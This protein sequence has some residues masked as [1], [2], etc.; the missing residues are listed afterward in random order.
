MERKKKLII[1]EGARDR[2]L[3]RFMP[4]FAKRGINVSISQLKQA[5]LAKFVNE[6]G[7]HNLSLDSNFYLLGVAKYYFNGDLTENRQLNLL[8]P[9][10][11][12]RFNQE[13]CQRLDA[14]IEILRNAYIDS[15]GTKW[16]QPED[17]GELTINKLLR[18]YG[19][20][21]NKALGIATNN[22]ED[23]GP[24]VSEDYS[25]GKDYTYEILYNFE[26]ARKYNAATE[27]GAWCITYGKA[28]F[29]GYV[30]RLGIHYVVF[31]RK[32]Y[33]NIPRK[34]GKGYTKSKPQDEYGNSLI[35]VLQSNS[36]PQ[37]I[38]ITSRWNHGAYNDNTQ[39]TEADHAYTTE[40]FL[41]VIGCDYS[42]LERAY[43]QW[44]E[45]SKTKK[46]KSG[47]SAAETRA[48][49]LDALRKLKYAQMLINGGANPFSIDFIQISLM[50]SNATFYNNRYR[51]NIEK[52]KPNIN[53]MFWVSV[54]GNGKTYITFID[55]RQIKYDFLVPDDGYYGSRAYSDK[56]V[57]LIKPNGY[58]MVY[59]K[60]RRKFLD[61][62]GTISFK[63]ASEAFSSYS[64][65]KSNIEYGILALSN[66]QLAL[67]DTTTLKPVKARNGSPWFET[68]IQTN[69]WRSSN[70]DNRGRIRMPVFN[71][72]SKTLKMVYDS[73]AGEV[74]YFNTG[75]GSFVDI[76]KDIPS[77]F[78]ITTHNDL[79]RELENYGDYVFFTEGGEHVNT[80][81]TPRTPIIIKNA[82]V[83]DVVEVNGKS[84]FLDFRAAHNVISFR[85]VDEVYS[86]YAVCGSDPC[87]RDAKLITLPNGEPVRTLYRCSVHFD[88][89]S[90]WYLISFSRWTKE[91]D[92]VVSHSAW[93]RVML[94]SASANA[95][96]H[97][98]ENS[99][100]LSGYVFK[101]YGSGCVIPRNS[102]LND[103][104]YGMTR[105]EGLRTG[106]LSQIVSAD[107]YGTKT[108]SAIRLKRIIR[109]EISRLIGM[110]I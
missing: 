92:T 105:A 29:D 102:L 72:G 40:E 87:F 48:E 43:Q 38:Y 17:F 1:Q 66:N 28:H 107:Q 110:P 35:C 90:K 68:I 106:N 108:E 41:N 63:Y 97:D 60:L 37:P 84:I 86:Y 65:L 4:L 82:R 45:I 73:A 9:R 59:D 64:S 30:S 71:Q 31:A 83:N 62:D 75:A 50:D 8:Y 46:A 56:Y 54:D 14:L 101:W 6:A 19:A 57:T 11:K 103:N 34:V 58:Y 88:E 96:Y 76:E 24:T 23:V 25:A 94:Y 53:S 91:N 21:I 78:A 26:D 69:S 2:A 3:E 99:T 5:L 85:P 77:N 52:D 44:K 18:K 39:G 81:G 95:F 16:E 36:S 100:D 47:N 70:A 12:D 104:P 7:M 51:I 32:G 61:V 13:V 33:E 49:K 67:I 93:D 20:K 79:C 80:Y 55:R 15:V 89:F 22:K 74:Y 10:V 42:V 27:P 109:E 98:K